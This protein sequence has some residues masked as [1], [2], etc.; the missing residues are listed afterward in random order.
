[1]SAEEVYQAVLDWARVG[2]VGPTDTALTNAQVIRADQ[3]APRPPK[4]Y[5]AVKVT[6]GDIPVGVD[7]EIDSLDAGTP[8]RTLRGERRGTLSIQGFGLGAHPLA[9]ESRTLAPALLRRDAAH[10]GWAHDLQLRW[11]HRPHPGPRHEHGAPLPAGVRVR[12]P[13]GRRPRGARGA[14][15]GSGRHRLHRQLGAP[16]RRGHHAVG[17]PSDGREP[18]RQHRHHLDPFGLQRHRKRALARCSSSWMRPM[19]QTSTATAPAC[20]RTSQER[21]RIR[22]PGTCQR[23]PCWP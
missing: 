21:R 1:M 20:T 7:E 12:A 9:G 18:P 2:A 3:D 4:P 23:R 13:P 19:G 8:T 14:R 17:G 10:R 15:G 22:P 5:V 6:V 16:R 11:H